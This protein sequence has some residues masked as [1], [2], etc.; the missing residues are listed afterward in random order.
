MASQ[1]KGKAEDEYI[2]IC[3]NGKNRIFDRIDLFVMKEPEKFPVEK[4]RNRRLIS[5]LKIDYAV[6][7]HLV[8]KMLDEFLHG[9]GLQRKWALYLGDIFDDEKYVPQDV[10][11]ECLK[12][13]FC[14]LAKQEFFVIIKPHPRDPRG[15]YRSLRLEMVLDFEDTELA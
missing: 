13:L 15:K 7:D 8:D 6:F 9:V 10:K 2:F 14:C 3:F 5:Y 12:E 4:L 11:E 1:L